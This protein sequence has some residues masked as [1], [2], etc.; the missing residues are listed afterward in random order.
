M[1]CACSNPARQRRG[2][3]GEGRR[4]SAPDASTELDDESS[5]R[6]TLAVNSGAAASIRAANPPGIVRRRGKDGAG[7]VGRYVPVAQFPSGALYAHK[8][9]RGEDAHSGG[10]VSQA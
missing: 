10:A 3:H 9:P 4:A 5:T 7:A 8:T 2:G 1:K 6:S